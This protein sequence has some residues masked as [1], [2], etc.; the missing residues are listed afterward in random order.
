VTRRR[1]LLSSS[2]LR[3][4]GTALALPAVMAGFFGGLTLAFGVPL[5]WVCDQV[6]ALGVGP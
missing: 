5:A 6:R 2:P 3:L 1:P 4:L